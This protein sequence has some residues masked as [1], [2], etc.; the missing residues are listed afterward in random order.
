MADDQPV[1]FDRDGFRERL[2]NLFGENAGIEGPLA[3][4]GAGRRLTGV[5]LRPRLSPE[6][7]TFLLDALSQFGILSIAGQDLTTFS[8]DHFERFA[9]H[10]GAPVPHPSNFTRGGKPAQSDGDSDG[11]VEWIPFERRRVA[12]VNAVFSDQL[13]C[14]PHE[15]PTVLVVTNFRGDPSGG[16][17]GRR[18]ELVQRGR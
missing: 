9:N 16:G 2:R 1:A 6:Q 11:P 4:S 5:D 8:L 17:P 10:W 3:V 12:A 14:L 18:P 15:S 13:Q 7:V